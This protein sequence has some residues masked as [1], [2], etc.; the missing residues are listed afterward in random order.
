MTCSTVKAFSTRNLR[1]KI[2]RAGL[3]QKFFGIYFC[4]HAAKLGKK[5]TPRRDVSI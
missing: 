1:K 5:E 4:F 2:S 3:N